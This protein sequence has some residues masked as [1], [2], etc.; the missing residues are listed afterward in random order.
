[1]CSKNQSMMRFAGD[2]EGRKAGRKVNTPTN[3]NLTEAKH[4]VAGGRWFPNSFS[5]VTEV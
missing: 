3:E 4:T 5:T 2:A 1:M